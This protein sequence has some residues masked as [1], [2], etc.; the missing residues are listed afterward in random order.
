MKRMLLLLGIL[1]VL[2]LN[3]A[4]GADRYMPGSYPTIQSA[5]NAANPG[6]TIFVAP[7]SYNEAIYINKNIALICAEKNK[8][9]DFFYVMCYH[10]S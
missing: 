4:F 5:I 2:G 3:A 8:Q 7:G 6:D 9:L 10:T 1:G